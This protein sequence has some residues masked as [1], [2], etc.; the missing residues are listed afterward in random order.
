MG[1]SVLYEDHLDEVALEERNA[2]INMIQL[3]ISFY[4]ICFISTLAVSLLS[5]GF[6]IETAVA[7]NGCWIGLDKWAFGLAFLTAIKVI[8]Q[9]ARLLS[10]KRHNQE[11]IILHVGGNFVLMPILWLCFFGVNVWLK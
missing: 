10:Y 4:A 7:L 9:V 11:S 1:E 2:A 6:F 5:N 8:I 3:E